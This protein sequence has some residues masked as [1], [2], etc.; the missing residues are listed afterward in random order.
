MRIF[1]P[2]YSTALRT[3]SQLLTH[4]L[5]APLRFANRSIASPPHLAALLSLK[6]AVRVY[7]SL[8]SDLSVGWSGTRADVA[9]DVH[10]CANLIPGL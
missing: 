10:H 8:D 9:L 1:S 2:L 6:D 7:V 3:S 5:T 4:D